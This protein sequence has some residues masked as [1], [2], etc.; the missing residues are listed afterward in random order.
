MA[1]I[2]YNNIS[3]LYIDNNFVKMSASVETDASS[4][5]VQVFFFQRKLLFPLLWSML[6]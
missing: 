3:S 4:R 6:F 2:E 1:K 5:R